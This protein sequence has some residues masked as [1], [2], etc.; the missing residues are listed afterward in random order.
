MLIYFS[1]TLV[2]LGT[3]FYFQWLFTR[4]WKRLPVYHPPFRQNLSKK[5]TVLIP[6]RNEADHIEACIQSLLSQDYPASLFEIIVLDNHS[7]DNTV[8]LANKYCSDRIKVF[9]LDQVLPEA[10][11]FKKEVL[12]FGIA[13]AQGEIILTTDADCLFTQKWVRTMVGYLEQYQL[14]MVTGPVQLS[15]NNK[16]IERY[17]QLDF[18]G[19]MIITGGGHA[20]KKLISANGANL[21]FR[22]EA[23]YL[24]GEYADNSQWASGDDLFLI[25]K[26]FLLVPEST[27]FVKSSAAIVTT[28]SLPRFSAF[29]HQRKRWASKSSGLP[30]R[31]TH[32]MHQLI[33]LN[34]LLLC[35]HILLTILYGSAYFGLFIIHLALKSMADYLVLDEGNTFFGQNFTRWDWIRSFLFNPYY[36]VRTGFSTLLPGYEWKA[37]KVER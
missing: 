8:K 2:I 29:W 11:T 24:V 35:M 30:H 18:A 20:S 36:I 12:Q 7:T 21:A 32:R 9:S 31:P 37:R 13:Q 4:A 25:Q 16:F 19:L 15:G 34:S 26:M 33:F 28:S 22:R 23:Y 27:S 6:T 3:Y 17:Q 10:E 5:V 1:F 14:K